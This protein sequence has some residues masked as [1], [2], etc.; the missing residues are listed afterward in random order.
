MNKESLQGGII[1]PLLFNFDTKGC[2]EDIV[3]HD[4]ECK[5]GL[6][7]WNLLAYADDIA[8]MDPSLKVLQK[9]FDILGERLLSKSLNI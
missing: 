3:I 2:I 4:L 5:I 9:L 6:I 1:S 8:L 7:K